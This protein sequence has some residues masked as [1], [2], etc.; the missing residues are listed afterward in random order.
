MIEEVPLQEVL[1][2]ETAD[3]VAINFFGDGTCNV[4]APPLE[5]PIRP[6]DDSQ[7]DNQQLR[8]CACPWSFSLSWQ[9]ARCLD[10]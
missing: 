3:Q 7:F 2:E 5:T 6:Q 9:F 1:G 8:S 10:R 4:G